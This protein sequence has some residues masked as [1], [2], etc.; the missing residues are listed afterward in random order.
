MPE[1]L[2]E[3]NLYIS[4]T[5]ATAAHL[6]CCG[7]GNEVITPFTPTDWRMTFDGETISLHPSIGN[8]SFPCRSH[9]IIKGG[10]VVWAGDM[11]VEAIEA[12]RVRDRIAKS[13]QY[14]EESVHLSSEKSAMQES[15]SVTPVIPEPSISTRILKRLK[16]WF[17]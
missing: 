3:S 1:T 11:S 6:C 4:M 5:F 2:Q 16:R 8:W 13:R 17:S 15:V 7:C 10:K 14:K 12:G 9:Y